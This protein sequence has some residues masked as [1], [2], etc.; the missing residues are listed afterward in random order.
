MLSQLILVLCTWSISMKDQCQLICSHCG[1]A[2]SIGFCFFLLCP[3]IPY[4]LFFIQSWTQ[5]LAHS[6]YSARLLALHSCSNRGHL[7]RSS[8]GWGTV[9]HCEVKIAFNVP[10]ALS[11]GGAVRKSNW[12]FVLTRFSGSNVGISLLP[13][14]CGGVFCHTIVTAVN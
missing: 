3:Y 8:I 14:R 7:R 2:F 13:E 11:L 9:P 6:L 4:I 1:I 10:G 12:C 5:F